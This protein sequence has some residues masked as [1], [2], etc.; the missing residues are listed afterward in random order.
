MSARGGHLERV[1]IEHLD[2][3]KIEFART[4]R[5]K[6]PASEDESESR[7]FP[8]GQIV[9]Y[10]SYPQGTHHSNA[11]RDP[12]QLQMILAEGSRIINGCPDDS[13]ASAHLA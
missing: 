2:P 13:P 12:E 7:S 6:Y 9:P 10:G 3:A 11:P 5:E 4:Y 8:N 1:T